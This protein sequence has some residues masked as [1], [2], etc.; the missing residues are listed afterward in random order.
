MKAEFYILGVLHRGDF[1]PYEMKRRLNNALVECYTDVD[2]GTL[3]YAVRQLVESGDIAPRTRQKVARGGERT[4]YRITSQGRRRFQE[5]LLERFKEQGTVAQ[6][7]YPA[8]LFL[9][10]ADLPAVAEILH[11]RLRQTE[12]AMA[13]TSAI[14]KQLGA[15]LGSGNS[16]LMDHLIQIRQLDCKSLRRL[17]REVETGKI[18][19]PQPG[20]IKQLGSLSLGVKQRS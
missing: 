16:H 10:L 13:K 14:K 2:V 12:S 6:T 3:Y 8:L 1:H 18:R 17:L 20:A 5:L 19:A 9:D 11:D 4:I 7:I 15:G